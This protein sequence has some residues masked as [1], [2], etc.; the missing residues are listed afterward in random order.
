MRMYS[1][2][3]L[4]IILISLGVL[5]LIRHI[6]NINIPIFRILVG[7]IFLYI[8]I[9]IIF[10][11]TGMKP[12]P[13]LVFGEGTIEA[14]ALDQEYNVI[15]SNGVVDLTNLPSLDKAH[16]LKVNT[17]FASGAIRINP[18]DPIILKVNS[19]FAHAS[20]PD[21]SSISFGN[22]TYMTEAFK[23]DTNYLEIE[24]SVIFGR[25]I[26]EQAQPI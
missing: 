13:N 19:V 4:G 9:S 3:F 5:L 11:E 18:Q 6:F 10:G 25:L 12:G 7:I 14:T 23:S 1:E 26:I 2:Y 20:L 21:N 22:N 24:A 17:I 8:G 16:K 15:F